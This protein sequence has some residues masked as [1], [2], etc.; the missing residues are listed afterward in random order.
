ML[1][2]AYTDTVR[3]RGKAK[4]IITT[5]RIKISI[6]IRNDAEWPLLLKYNVEY[7]MKEYKSK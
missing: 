3:E 2:V 6:I 4:G 1:L 5:V 7:T